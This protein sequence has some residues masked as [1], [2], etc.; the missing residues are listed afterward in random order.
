M[1]NSV[2]RR[3]GFSA[4]CGDDDVV[5]SGS[6]IRVEGRDQRQA[7]KAADDLSGDEPRR[8]ARRDAR[9]GVGED[10]TDRDGGV[11]E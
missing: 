2:D 4:W 9:E 5:S 3:H 1:S 6:G 10:P 8:R 11:G 7:E